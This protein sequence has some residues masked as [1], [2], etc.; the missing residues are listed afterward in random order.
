MD[1]FW[2]IFNFPFQIRFHCLINLFW[3]IENRLWMLTIEKRRNP[4]SFH[5]MED[6][7]I[8]IHLLFLSFSFG[9]NFPDS[10]FENITTYIYIYIYKILHFRSKFVVP[11]TYSSILLGKQNAK[12]EY[13]SC[14]FSWS[15]NNFE[16]QIEV[17]YRGVLWTTQEWNLSTYPQ[18]WRFQAAPGE[19]LSPRRWFSP[20]KSLYQ[21]WNQNS[22]NLVS[23]YL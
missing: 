13:F 19:H 6:K 2:Q 5:R 17:H 22:K 12:F 23:K 16:E 20:A 14:E 15:K 11:E 3:F 7:K 21:H 4:F 8:S 18:G 1:C 10:L 9:R